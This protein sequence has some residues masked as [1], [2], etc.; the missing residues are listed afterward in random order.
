[1]IDQANSGDQDTIDLLFSACYDRFLGRV[2]IKLPEPD[3]AKEYCSFAGQK[4]REESSQRQFDLNQSYSYCNYISFVCRTAFL[5]KNYYANMNKVVLIKTKAMGSFV[6]NKAQCEIPITDI[7]PKGMN[8]QEQQVEQTFGRISGQDLDPEETFI[9]ETFHNVNEAEK[10]LKMILKTLAFIID[11]ASSPHQSVAYW[12]RRVKGLRNEGIIELDH[13]PF[14]D[15]HRS[16]MK[17]D[18][19]LPV[20]DDLKK[21]IEDILS[22][23]GETLNKKVNQTYSNSYKEIRKDYGNKK[24][25]ILFISLFYTDLGPT[26]NIDNWINRLKTRMKEKLKINF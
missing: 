13:T 16:T 26:N 6:I 25:G 15:L 21:K 11:Y 14:F 3:I 2:M 18:Y 1:M 7:K 4:M 5:R 9:N 24:T 8:D 20:F 22:R 23:F 12:L 17:P 19:S 10:R